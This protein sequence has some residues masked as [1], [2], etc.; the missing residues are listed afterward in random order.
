MA[1][2]KK[3]QA[4]ARQGGAAA[5]AASFSGVGLV[6]SQLLPLSA[7]ELN[8]GQVEGLPKNPRTINEDKYRKLKKSIQDHPD[9]MA[10]REIL[11]LKH[12][13]KYVIIGGNMRFRA[14][15]ELGYK[16]AVCKVIPAGTDV[17][18]IK[19]YLIKDNSSFG[20]WDVS[21][22]A[23]SWNLAQLADWGI[24]LPDLDTNVPQED[25]QED[26]FNPGDVLG[27]APTT[28][29][30]D[31]FQLGRHR[32]ICGDSTDPDVLKLL[33]GG[34]EAD[35]I[36][37]DPPYNVDYSAKNE[38]LNKADKGN[39][40]Q[41]DIAN[42]KMTREQFGDFLNKAFEGMHSIAKP[43][44]AIYIFYAS[45]EAVNFVRAF[46]G[47]GFEYKQQLIWVKNNMV[48]GLQDYQWK[49]EPIL[50]GWKGG[51]PHYFVD[52]R[53]QLTVYEDAAAL[54]LDKMSKNELK[55]A[56]KD[57]IEAAQIPNTAIHENKPQVSADH[58]T[59]K[60]VKL[61]GRL[62]KNSTRP[63]EIVVDI[64]GGSGSTLIAAD[65]LGRACFTC[66]LDPA[67]CDVIIKRWEKQ[68]GEKAQRIGN[69]VAARGGI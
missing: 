56:L 37:T 44:A 33:M 31:I 15:K 26:H 16:D 17:E 22:L 53:D 67:Y 30:G 54:E 66:E 13:E 45:R 57:L 42:D 34:R 46:E 63:G 35:L 58:P 3:Q 19:A 8:K 62:L 39:R 36:L 23:N 43:G 50:Y 68:S 20:D 60:P 52:R 11:V 49:H 69:Y 25:A 51:K 6:P 55:Q 1:D 12:G 10:L 47:A 48:L 9:M 40:I 21:E 64:F 61:C 4:A 24:D 29:F 18:D 65:Q 5:P 32:L 59:M 41:K 2:T 28:Q 27:K 14:L 7:L 38:V